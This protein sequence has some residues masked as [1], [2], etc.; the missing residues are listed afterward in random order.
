M[1]YFNQ[2][3]RSIYIITFF[4]LLISTAFA[5]PETLKY[6]VK[7]FGLIPFGKAL[8]NTD[9]DRAELMFLPSK[10]VWWVS[11]LKAKFSMQKNKYLTTYMEDIENQIGSPDHKTLVYD[12]KNN[13]LEYTRGEFKGLRKKIPQEVLDPFSFLSNLRKMSFEKG[14]EYQFL[15][16]TNQSNYVLKCFVEKEEVIQ[17]KKTWKIHSTLQREDKLHKKPKLTMDFWMTKEALILAKAHTLIGP[18][19]ISL[20]Q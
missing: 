7:Y 12:H 9:E 15:L 8:L 10:P 20:V 18:V 19:T 16:N 6:K 4:I 1:I 5:A 2:M 14:K 17:S 3:A 13:I 11:K